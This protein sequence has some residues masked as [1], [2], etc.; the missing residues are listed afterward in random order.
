VRRARA[1]TAVAADL[2]HSNFMNAAA[3]ALEVMANKP[4]AV[5]NVSLPQEDFSAH[6]AK[7]LAGVV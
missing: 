5:I 1:R 4:P 3:A 6:W 2:E 7:G